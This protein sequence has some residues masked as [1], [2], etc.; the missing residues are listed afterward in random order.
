M[1]TITGSPEWQA[2]QQHYRDTR[3]THLRERFARDS[4]RF[5]RMHETLGGLLFDYSKNLADETTLDLLCRLAERAQV[6]EKAEA[7]RSGEI[8][9]TSEQRAVLHTALRLPAGAEPVYVRGENIVP[10]VH[11]ELERALAFADALIDGSYTNARSEAFTDLVHIGIGGSDLGPQTAVQALAPYHQRLRVHFVANADDAAI[12]QL[13]PRLNP[14]TTLFS[15]ASKSFGTPE[16]LLN[17]QTARAWF[18]RQGMAESDVSRHFVAVSSNLPAVAAFGIAP[19]RTFAMFDW[20][21]GRYSLWSAIGLPVMAAVGSSRFRELLAGAHEADRHFFQTAYRRNIPV[22][23]ALLGVWY[24]NFHGAH[25]HAVIPYSHLL[26][27]LPAHLQQTDMESN[28]KHIRL[29]GRPVDYDTGPIIWGEEGVN[30]QHAFFQLIHQG[31]RLIPV[32]FIVP[33]KT[34]Y[35]LGKQ[36]RFVV[37]NALAQ[38]EALMNGKTRTE[39]ASGYA[40][41]PSEIRELLAAA[42]E[43]EGNRPSNMLL[44]DELTPYN[45][46]LLMALYEHKIFVQSVIW[47]LNAFDQWGVEYGKVLAKNILR[48]L[49]GSG[50]AAHDSST[51]ALIAHYRKVSGN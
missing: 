13:L 3:S 44:I 8:I 49:D 30:C 15:I 4:D 24:A 43:F 19:E 32:D 20:V 23:M 46:G 10:S 14:H 41:R 33:L 11:R 47:D 7:M 35:G 17:A 25:S 29:N 51:A 26:R 50:T 48:E 42:N 40:D 6:A 39:A 16:T 38:A 21:G 31:T 1:S 28:G 34:A 36:H 5:A 12:G 18:L 2:L 9:N 37:A 22:L 45:L 27:R